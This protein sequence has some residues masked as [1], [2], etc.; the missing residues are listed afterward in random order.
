[1]R[2]LAPRGLIH[3]NHPDT[4]PQ[5]E[6]LAR[7]YTFQNAKT[8]EGAAISAGRKIATMPIIDSP[9]NSLRKAENDQDLDNWRI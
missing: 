8:L 5:S 9:L 7:S 4:D 2:S 1:M 3:T 6:I